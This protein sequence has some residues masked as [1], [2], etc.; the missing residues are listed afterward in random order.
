MIRYNLPEIDPE[1]FK[2]LLQLESYLESINWIKPYVLLIKIRASQI[3][4]CA[5]CLKMHTSEAIE[6]GETMKRISLLSK[7]R[8]ER[9]FSE[10]E[11]LILKITEAVTFISNN[12]LTN[13]LYRELE[14]HFTTKQISQIV[15]AIGLIN[16]WNRVVIASG[17]TIKN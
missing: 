4:N 11:K 3:N 10:Q 5:Y 16:L 1:G 17:I 7:W 6:S 8:L 14:T 15:F 13:S 9:I 2:E 12:G